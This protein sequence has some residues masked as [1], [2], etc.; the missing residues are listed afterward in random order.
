[1]NDELMMVWSRGHCIYSSV[2][3]SA[4]RKLV[5]ISDF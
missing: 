1:M 3:Q 2:R 4:G 5:L